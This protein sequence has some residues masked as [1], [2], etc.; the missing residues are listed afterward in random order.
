MPRARRNKVVSLTKTSKQTKS[1]K[2]AFADKV[3]E[4]A[5]A[6]PY[7]WLFTIGNQRNAYIKEVRQLWEGSR[8]FYGKLGVIRYALGSEAQ[9]E[10]RPGISA[11]SNVRILNSVMPDDAGH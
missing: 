7:A 10:L 5:N 6:F 1:D 8:I 3:R 2:E 4:A 11:L 9:D